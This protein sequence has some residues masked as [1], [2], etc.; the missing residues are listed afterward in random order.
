M[1]WFAEKWSGFDWVPIAHF[2]SAAEADAYADAAWAARRQ[3][4]RVSARTR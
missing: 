2:S 1:I 3:I 4:L